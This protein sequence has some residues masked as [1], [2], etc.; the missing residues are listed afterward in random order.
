MASPSLRSAQSVI[1]LV[2]I[3]QRAPLE[4]LL[5]LCIIRRGMKEVLADAREA[6]GAEVMLLRGVATCSHRQT[7]P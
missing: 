6:Q 5:L 4:R 7:T 2:E 3:D 1:G